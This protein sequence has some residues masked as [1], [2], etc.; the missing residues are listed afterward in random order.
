MQRYKGG[1]GSC[2]NLCGLILGLAG[3]KKKIEKIKKIK[4]NSKLISRTLSEESCNRQ[5]YSQIVGVCNYWWYW[6]FCHM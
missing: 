3:Q 1:T 4:N 5:H 6:S 2:L